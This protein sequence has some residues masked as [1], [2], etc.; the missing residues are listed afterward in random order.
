MLQIVICEDNK[1]FLEQLANMIQSILD[2]NK[3][4]GEILCTTA[5]ARDVEFAIA[6][7]KA[8]TF[9]LDIDLKNS[10]NG[11]TLAEKIRKNNPYAYIVF[12][13]GHFEYVLQAFKVYSFDFLQ[14][15]ITFEILEQCL[16]R[17]YDHYT[18]VSNDCKYIE[19]KSGASLYKIK[20]DNIVYIERFKRDTIIYTKNSQIT[21]HESLESLLKRLNDTNFVRCHKSFI[22]SRQLI[23]QIDQKERIIVFE[24][25]QKCPLG[26][27]YKN[28]IGKPF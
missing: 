17:I 18:V 6:S 21:C 10:E 7:G 11:Y 1:E 12:V 5:N 3:I 13:T 28:D 4:K 24:T 15:P 9:F 23:T 25:G 14:K 22:A 16:Q 27:K 20:I 19:V 2:N 26:R 8:N